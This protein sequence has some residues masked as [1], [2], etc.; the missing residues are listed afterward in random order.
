MPDFSAAGDRS[1]GHVRAAVR[2][3]T[4]ARSSLSS[5]A[6]TDPLLSTQHPTA[7][8]RFLTSA[9]LNLPLRVS[10]AFGSYLFI[11]RIREVIIFGS[12]GI[13][14][15]A[16]GIWLMVLDDGTG[17]NY[18]PMGIVVLPIGLF[19]LAITPV[20]AKRQLKN[21][22][23]VGADHTGVCLRPF[24]DKNRVVFVPW[25]GVQGVYI[26]RWAGPQLVVKPGDTVIEHQFALVGKG[27]A[28]A[29]VG[30]AIAQR[31]RTNPRAASSR[32]ARNRVT[33]GGLARPATVAA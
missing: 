13:L 21:G 4:G 27:S 7:V 6:I 22:F 23:S 26:R 25:E 5:C 32:W 17:A 31:F 14:T 29:E 19:M 28:G 15:L 20:S 3:S 10:L 33:A 30:T 16:A 18:V 8:P 11:S 12:F 24:L 1:T 9:P 2:G